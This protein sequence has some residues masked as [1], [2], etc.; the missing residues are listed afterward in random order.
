ML[1]LPHFTTGFYYVCFISSVGPSGEF[2]TSTQ[3]LKLLNYAKITGRRMCATSLNVTLFDTLIPLLLLALFCRPYFEFRGQNL[4]FSSGIS[5]HI[6][7]RW[8]CILIIFN[9]VFY[10]CRAF[11]RWR[12]K[13]QHPFPPLLNVFS[14]TMVKVCGHHIITLVRKVLLHL[15][16]R[17]M[18]LHLWGLIQLWSIYYI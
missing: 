5:L 9:K 16:V 7:C 4:A 2:E 12:K 1:F 10:D 18:L 3:N 6:L 11:L 17:I 14:T 8:Y 15:F 13:I